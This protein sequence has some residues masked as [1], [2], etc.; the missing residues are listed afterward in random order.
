MAK[1]RVFIVDDSVVIRRL[2]TISLGED[3]ALEGDDERTDVE[4]LPSVVPRDAHA[5]PLPFIAGEQRTPPAPANS[6][7][8]IGV[9]YGLFQELVDRAVGI[10]AVSARIGHAADRLDG[11][12][13]NQLRELISDV[14]DQAA[15]LEARLTALGG[16]GHASQLVDALSAKLALLLDLDALVEQARVPFRQSRSGTND[17]ASPPR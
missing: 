2:S 17:T 8:D 13:T 14:A 10:A 4:P 1:T 6:D 16:A 12:Q 3:P 5:S 9:E 7:T 15:D 11:L